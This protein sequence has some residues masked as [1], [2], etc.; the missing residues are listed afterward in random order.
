M[1]RYTLKQPALFLTVLSLLAPRFVS[2][3]DNTQ[4]DPKVENTTE[5]QSAEKAREEKGSPL[6]DALQKKFVEDDSKY[7]GRICTNVEVNSLTYDGVTEDMMMGKFDQKVDQDRY[8]KHQ[9][10][11]YVHPIIDGEHVVEMKTVNLR[12]QLEHNFT[13]DDALRFIECEDVTELVQGKGDE[14]KVSAWTSHLQQIGCEARREKIGGGIL[15]YYRD[16]ID[17]PTSFLRLIL[18]KNEPWKKDTSDD[19]TEESETWKHDT[20]NTY[21]CRTF[22]DPTNARDTFENLPDTATYLETFGPILNWGVNANVQYMNDRRIVLNRMK[23]EEKQTEE[24]A[25][26]ALTDKEKDQ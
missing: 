25:A 17:G 5:S 18:K 3:A 21:A 24:A 15:T 23:E 16:P 8:L 11:L 13:G 14:K 4:N 6:A 19:P 7:W 12:T 22:D 26:S 20:F 9:T 2:S 1:H 10:F